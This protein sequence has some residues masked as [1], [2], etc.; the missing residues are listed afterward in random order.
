MQSILSLMLQVPSL[1]M[2]T[3]FLQVLNSILQCILAS[4]SMYHLLQAFSWPF[5]WFWLFLYLHFLSLKFI[6]LSYPLI[7]SLLFHLSLCG[8][9][10]LKFQDRKKIN[11]QSV[12]FSCKSSNWTV[13]HPKILGYGNIFHAFSFLKVLS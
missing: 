2:C 11:G 8:Y 6:Q 13:N 1:K 10:L 4:F 7:S 5:P 12:I 3:W 9:T